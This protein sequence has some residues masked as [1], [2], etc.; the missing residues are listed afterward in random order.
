M[1]VIAGI[2]VFAIPIVVV[3]IIVQGYKI[4][5]TLLSAPST[6][7]QR[8]KQA[9]EEENLEYIERHFGRVRID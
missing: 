9:S 2:F 1:Q 3:L 8:D 6:E 7:E 4:F 5:R